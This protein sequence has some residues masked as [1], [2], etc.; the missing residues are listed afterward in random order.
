MYAA[1]GIPTVV[2][3]EAGSVLETRQVPLRE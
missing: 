1:E 3:V 2:A